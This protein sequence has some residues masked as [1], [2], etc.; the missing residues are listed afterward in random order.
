MET[1]ETNTIDFLPTIQN[2]F[3]V[4]NFSRCS[5]ENVECLRSDE[6]FAMKN[7]MVIGE[8][9]WKCERKN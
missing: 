7:F 8:N 5:V 4:V 1:V 2:I 6:K 3:L 9:L